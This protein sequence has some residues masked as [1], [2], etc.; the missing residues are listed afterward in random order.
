MG[1]GKSSDRNF[2]KGV[3]Y[4][5]CDD[6]SGPQSGRDITLEAGRTEQKPEGFRSSESFQKT[7][8]KKLKK[9]LTK[10]SRDDKI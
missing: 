9:F 3:A 8:E 2:L 5:G 10:Q 4:I 6:L 1:V 7:F